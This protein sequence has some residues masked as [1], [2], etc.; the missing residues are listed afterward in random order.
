MNLPQTVD[1][2]IHWDISTDR[3]T[4]GQYTIITGFEGSGGCF[5]CGKEL[6]GRRRFCGHRSGCWTKYQDHFYWPFARYE[7]LKRDNYRCVNC[8]TEAED[9]PWS[10]ANWE[11]SA[12]VR[13]SQLKVHHI[14]PLEGKDRAM[15]PYNLQWNLIS[16]CH[17][18]HKYIH[19]VMRNGDKP[20]A[21]DIFDLA[22]T[23][24]QAVFEPC[25][26]L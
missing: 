9:I 23:K 25:L 5:W 10:Y 21:P 22:Q 2:L 1:E 14:I 18:C 26:S 11:S 6:T 16:L 12:S 15:S 17:R 4:Y 3:D 8:G 13:E 7:C 24:G 19:V 20:P